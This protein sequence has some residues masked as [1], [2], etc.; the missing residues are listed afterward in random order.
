VKIVNLQGKLK[1]SKKLASELS[2]DFFIESVGK[3]FASL[4]SLKDLR[5]WRDEC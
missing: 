1:S 5:T 2:F 4:L 3:W